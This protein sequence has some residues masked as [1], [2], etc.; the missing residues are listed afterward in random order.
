MGTKLFSR[1]IRVTVTWQPSAGQHLDRIADIVRE[2]M[3]EEESQFVKQAEL[4]P[5][6]RSGQ[7]S[8]VE[9]DLENR[10]AS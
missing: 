9:A 1:V 2:Q 4:S 7:E 6:T 8:L 10:V 5:L 3:A